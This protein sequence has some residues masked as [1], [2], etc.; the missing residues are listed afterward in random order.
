MLES[1]ART[2][3]TGIAFLLDGAMCVGV[4]GDDLIVRCEKDETEG[5]LARKG[6][7]EFDLS[8]GR[9][10]KGWI[11]VG[12][13]ATRT[14]AGLRGWIDFA[15]TQAARTPKTSKRAAKGRSTKG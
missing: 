4:H 6:V 12:P 10:M 14:A 5:L 1:D 3:S 11:L 2:R 8:G 13:E 9:A 7:R 15:R